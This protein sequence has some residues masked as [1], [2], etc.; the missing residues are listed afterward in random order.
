VKRLTAI[1]RGAADAVL[2]ADASP[3]EDAMKT[4]KRTHSAEAALERITLALA[5][6]V[7]A[8]RASLFLVDQERGELRIAAAPCEATRLC[9]TMPFDRGIA[10]FVRRTGEALC[11]ADA[12]GDPRFNPAVDSDTGFHTRCLACV[13]VKDREGRVIALVE[14]LN[15]KDRPAFDAFDVGLVLSCEPELRELIEGCGPRARAA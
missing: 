9:V 15:A 3:P 1:A 8:E 5:D 7:G 11:V 13:P 2:H 14:L 12:Y 4:R 10:G 6:A